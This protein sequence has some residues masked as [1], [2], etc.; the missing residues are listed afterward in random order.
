MSAR[1]LAGMRVAV[2]GATGFLGRHLVPALLDAG[3]AVS[4]IARAKSDTSRLPPGARIF[5]ADLEHGSGLAGTLDG[6]DELI[7]M[8]ALL[9]GLGWQD[10]LEANARVAR[11]LARAL[12][13]LARPP[14]VTLVSSLAASGPCAEAPGVTENSDLVPV[15]AYGWSKL[16]C[17]RIFSALS[18]PALAII[19]PPIIYGSG[20]RGLLPLFRAARLGFG[21][22]PGLGRD[23]PVSLIH[24]SDVA[25]AIILLC[26]RRAS[27][28][29]HVNDGAIHNMASFCRAMGHAQ[30]RMNLRVVKVP[31]ALMGASAWLSAGLS[32]ALPRAL[33]PRAFGLNPDKY[34]EAA[35]AGWLC[36]AGSIARDHGF[37]PAMPL[38]RGL[39]ETVAGYRREGWL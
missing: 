1:P 11:S 29:Y 22:S 10:Y 34:R 3:A 15:S 5:R 12:C 31:L 9:F 20:D 25:R 8:A 14:H 24:A 17:E 18:G 21:I 4:C 39:E 19:R 27:G 36:D 26:R 23:F 32:C 28:V 2:T 35:A 30:G 37:A 38:A 33:R 13:G 7:H 16:L 6:Q